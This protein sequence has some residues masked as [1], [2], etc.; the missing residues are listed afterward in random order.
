MALPQLFPRDLDR[1]TD[2][3]IMNI[4]SWYGDNT[5]HDT[6]L[7][8]PLSFDASVHHLTNELG[9]EA[10]EIELQT[11]HGVEDWLP[12]SIGVAVP[13]IDYNLEVRY[14]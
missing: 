8:F 2:P 14:R 1:V 9:L 13:S 5:D 11:P 4:D 6:T 3:Q 12:S 7:N 10:S